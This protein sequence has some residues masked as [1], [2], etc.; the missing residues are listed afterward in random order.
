MLVSAVAVT[1]C[2]AGRP[3]LLCVLHVCVAFVLG[4]LLFCLLGRLPPQSPKHRR[5]ASLTLP[6]SDSP[7]QPRDLSLSP[8]LLTRHRQNLGVDQEDVAHRQER[9]HARCVC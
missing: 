7:L 6:T 8:S 9:A 1:T 2:F 3:F 4:G 5:F